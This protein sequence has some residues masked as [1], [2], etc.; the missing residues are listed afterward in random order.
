M[1]PNITASIVSHGH[2]AMVSG[3]I[4]DLQVVPEISKIVVTQNIREDAF[5]P[6]DSRLE[7]RRNLK[8]MG[9]GANQNAVFATSTS[10][11]ICILNPDVRLCGN[12][13]PQLL[14]RFAATNIG[15]VAP[16]IVSPFGTE[17]ESARRFPTFR[18][19]V[20]KAL[21][22]NNSTYQDKL[23]S[24]M[25][26][27]DWLAGMFLLCRGEA[28]KAIG[29]FDEKYF[30]YY[31]DVDFCARL[32]S[33][34]FEICQDRSVQVM[35]DARKQSHRSWRYARWHLASMLRFLLQNRAL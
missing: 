28:F 12:P 21:G 20:S 29:G 19:L 32:R 7:V 16:R 30:L 3:L 6:H 25:F 9:Y 24:L 23:S 1:H 2:G 15:L 22:Q 11:Y 31:E 26:F 34:G 17:E 33:A 27:P 8:P 5:Y 4:E 35:H 10:P 13:F 18:T 14:S